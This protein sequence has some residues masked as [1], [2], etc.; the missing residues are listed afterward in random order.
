MVFHH[1][2]RALAHIPVGVAVHGQPPA[3]LDV[4]YPRA[5]DT[6]STVARQETY[7]S[8]LWNQ[9]RPT[10]SQRTARE[11]PLGAYPVR[12]AGKRTILRQPRCPSPDAGL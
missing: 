11:R 7:K 8:S 1:V 6:S 4:A 9:P 10:R 3:T 5:V 12:C 2:R